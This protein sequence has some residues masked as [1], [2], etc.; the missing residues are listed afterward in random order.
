MS[1]IYMG[2]AKYH[3]SSEKKLALAS[4]QQMPGSVILYPELLPCFLAL[5]YSAN[6]KTWYNSNAFHYCLCLSL[7]SKHMLQLKFVIYHRAAEAWIFSCALGVWINS[8]I[9]LGM[10]VL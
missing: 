2:I 1:V 8:G 5:I 3:R 7:S 9:S 4:I 10:I 6:P